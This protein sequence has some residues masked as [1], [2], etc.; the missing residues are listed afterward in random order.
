M[1][2]VVGSLP[3]RPWVW[4]HCCKTREHV[5]VSRHCPKLLVDCEHFLEMLAGRAV[6]FLALRC[7]CPQGCV[8][9]TVMFHQACEVSAPFLSWCTFCLLKHFHYA[10]GQPHRSRHLEHPGG[11]G[12][13]SWLLPF[14]FLMVVYLPAVPGAFVL[15]FPLSGEHF[16]QCL[17]CSLSGPESSVQGAELL[18]AG[19]FSQNLKHAVFL[20]FLFSHEISQPF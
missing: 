4:S 15:F 2:T 10:H 7:P 3:V 19:P 8:H 6:P 9:F 14:L 16:L 1:G 11:G 17:C 12:E 13:P 5:K 18:L 20:A